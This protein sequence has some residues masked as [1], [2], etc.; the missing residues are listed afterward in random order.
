MKN[1]D[2][3]VNHEIKIFKQSVGEVSSI[4]FEGFAKNYKKKVSPYDPSIS[5]SINMGKHFELY[6]KAEVK[7][8]PVKSD[9]KTKNSRK[10]SLDKFQSHQRA[11]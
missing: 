4:R 9:S 1:N 3:Q 8:S 11:S 2:R 6:R 10:R 7:G 5:S